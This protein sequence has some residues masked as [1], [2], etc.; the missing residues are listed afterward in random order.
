MW[1]YG[2]VDLGSA[3]ETIESVVAKIKSNK[4]DKSDLVELHKAVVELEKALTDEK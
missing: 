2:D 4:Y 3:V 1:Y